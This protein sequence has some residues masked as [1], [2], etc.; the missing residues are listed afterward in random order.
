[1]LGEFSD[2]DSPLGLVY[3]RGGDG[4]SASFSCSRPALVFA[5]CHSVFDLSL[6]GGAPDRLDSSSVLVLPSSMPVE[7]NAVTGLSHFAIFCPSRELL[8]ETSGRDGIPLKELFSLFSR[9]R[10]MAR[11]N[12]LNEIMHRFVFERA[13]LGR[14]LNFATSFLS[15]EI[16]KEVFYL[17]GLKTASPV[18]FN[19]DDS[20]FYESQPVMK[21]ALDYIETNLFSSLTMSGL[22]RNSFASE[23][24]LLR[25]FRKEFGRTPFEY[26]AGRRLEESL[27]LLR[28]RRY[29]VG[30]VAGLVGYASASSFIAAF[31]KK[32][33]VTPLEWRSGRVEG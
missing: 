25:I 5:R 13:D 7:L 31:H 20:G 11:N 9:P 22:A 28:N 17:S 29:G 3:C 16:I 2:W 26:I 4:F 1:M 8:G 14:N 27:A 32:F 24:T 19:M 6:D 10:R 15:V 33:G 30:E 21:R 12:W 18:V 23:S